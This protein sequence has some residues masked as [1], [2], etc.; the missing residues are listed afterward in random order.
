MDN[1]SKHTSK[2]PDAVYDS[3]ADNYESWIEES[4]GLKIIYRAFHEAIEGNREKL[5]G[6][7]LD[8]GCGTGIFSRALSKVDGVRE[9]LGL[10]ISRESVV[11]ARERCNGPCRFIA[12]SA[13]TLPFPDSSFD[14]VVAFGDIIS[15]IHNGHREAISEAARVIKPGGYL[16]FD[17]D[18]KWNLGLLSEPHELKASLETPFSGHLREWSF[19]DAF[20][21]QCSLHFKTFM[22]SEIRGLLKDAGLSVLDL[23]GLII[24]PNL[25]PQRYHY[26]YP[27]ERFLGKATLALARAD[28]LINRL[29]FFR[30]FGIGAL[31]VARKGL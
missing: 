26:N 24:L 19:L 17:I 23:R 4:A 28:R 30:G 11:Q 15:H 21:N 12:G 20:G 2:K 9:V 8:L 13:T 18:N 14:A 27:P 5:K 3:L 31:I 16:I 6:R 22:P 1:P 25:I 7:V 29:P 10:D